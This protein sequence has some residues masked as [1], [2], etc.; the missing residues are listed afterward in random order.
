MLCKKEYLSGLQS[1]YVEWTGQ[2]PNYPMTTPDHGTDDGEDHLYC[3]D[4]KSK[5]KKQRL[6]YI[7][8]YLEYYIN[9]SIVLW[10]DILYVP[11]D[12]GHLINKT[13]IIN[14]LGRNNTINR[15]PQLSSHL[16]CLHAEK[17]EKYIYICLHKK[18]L[19]YSNIKIL[20]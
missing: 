16:N 8:T 17:W 15:L 6:L 20:E 7:F 18:I 11:L 10:H 4:G 14:G 2:G 3:Y 19:F 5:K 9:V 12:H 1:R 13:C